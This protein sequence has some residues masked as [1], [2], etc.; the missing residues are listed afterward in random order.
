[1]FFEYLCNLLY[2]MTMSFE[3]ILPRMVPVLAAAVLLLG[4]G[5]AGCGDGGARHRRAMET[6]RTISDSIQ[7]GNMDDAVRRTA[8]LKS[9]ALADGDSLTWAEAVIEDA[10]VDY[11]M[12]RPG[13]LMAKADT[14]LG[15]LERQPHNKILS[16]TRAR[17]YQLKGGYYDQYH[18]NGDSTI[19]YMRLCADYMERAGDPDRLPQIY[20][21][22]AN[23]MRMGGHLDSA[24][25]YYH[26]AIYLCD[27]LDLKPGQF[28]PLYC[29]IAAVFTDMRDFDN[30]AKWW[31]RAM[32]QYGEMGPYDKFQAL[33]GLGNDLYYREDY[34][35]TERVFGQLRE[36]LDS[37]P[38]ARWEQM[39]TDVNLAD[40][41]LRLGTP[42][43]ATA[44]LDTVARFFTD[45]Q[46][47]PVCMSYIHT[48]QM[49]HADYTGDEGRVERLIAAHP[50]SD[51]MRLEQ[52][53]ARL[54]FL[55]NYYSQTARWE[56]AYKV[57]MKRDRLQDS[58]RSYR[59]RQQI[60][61]MNATYSRDARILRL[62]AA[63]QRHQAR[64]YRLLAVIGLVVI[65][66]LGLMVYVLH[67]RARQ[68]RREQKMVDKIVSLRQANLRNRITPHFIYNALNHELS[69]KEKPGTSHIDS[70]VS[71]LRRQQSVA[72][73]VLIPFADELAFV[74]DY[75]TVSADDGRGPLDYRCRIGEGIDTA[76]FMFPSMV[77]QI[78]VEN[79]FKHGFST[80]P[81]DA[82]RRLEIDVRREGEAVTV[83]V[84]N[85]SG[86]AA[87]SRPGGGTGLRVVLETIRLL[88]ERN[89]PASGF[90][91]ETDAVHDGL[92]GC[93]ATVTV[94]ADLHM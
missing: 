81:P 24:A 73:E 11:Y 28:Q 15:W 29:G 43:R 10:T 38:G 3:T 6:I 23:A 71:L 13:Q 37:V 47:N 21:N 92:R 88:N 62:Q 55:D 12:A 90:K 44:V 49:R 22:L 82:G 58:L 30:S 74:D 85:N 27:S 9:E 68:R 59:L 45:E 36:F 66:L 61:A 91:L 16:G 48:L 26:R 72:G 50:V 4:P 56:D 83:S 51:T 77:L 41:W 65:C 69:H 70:I 2:N 18:F 1:M 33:S 80:L 7:T 86:T 53:L 32:S 54:E 31:E 64:I 20:G 46:P 19:R 14:V 67:A 76:T 79:A 57:H 42:Q 87:A 35:G 60:S 17:A 75:I 63:T 40:A 34:K 25:Y 94:P 84:F 78:L 39:F 93:L 8:L 5:L 52:R 89:R